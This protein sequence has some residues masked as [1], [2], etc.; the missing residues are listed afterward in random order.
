MKSPTQSS[1]EFPSWGG[2]RPGA[3]RKPEGPRARVGHRRRPEHCARHPL[4][5]TLRLA[6]DLPSLR[7]HDA[8][9]IVRRAV[10][11]A[12]AR[13][14]LRI[15]QYSAQSNHLHLICEAPDRRA[16]CDGIKGLSVRLARR[17]NDHWSR[18][19][20]VFVERFHLRSLRTPLEVR[21]ALVYVLLN[22]RKHDVRFEGAFDPCSS[23]S[24]FE[25]WRDRA[26]EKPRDGERAL[27]APETWL[28]AHGWRHHGPIA[29]DELDARS[30]AMVP[31]ARRT[32]VSG[33]RRTE[34]P[35]AARRAT[36]G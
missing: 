19:G 25:G 13:N 3:G 15:V 34:R 11:D 32:N 22:A 5:V 4:H 36:P 2:P 30:A 14:G 10:R 23:A 28:L 27:A 9:R 21:R 35:I 8:H 6:D 16:L 12:S 24:E 29:V 18:T 33:A 1:F 7:E 20:P 17:L 26:P 31:R